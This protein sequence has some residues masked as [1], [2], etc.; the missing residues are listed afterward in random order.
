MTSYDIKAL[1]LVALTALTALTAAWILQRR[2]SRGA[3]LPLPPGPKGLPLL[4]NLL[5]MP[6]T[7]GWYKFHE[8]C[9]ELGTDIL[10]L[11][12][13]GTN[14]IVI[15]TA[16]VANDLLEKRSSIYS[17][18]P[19]MTMLNELSG[20][21]FNFGF[22]DYGSYWRT[23]RKLV[24][25]TFNQGVV[26]HFKPHVTRATRNMLNRFLDEPRK[27]EENLRNMAAE[28]IITVLYG[29]EVR[30]KDDFYMLTAARGVAPAIELLGAPGSRIVD[31]LPFLKHVPDWLPGVTFRH[32]AEEAKRAVRAM[33]EIPYKVSKDAYDK[34]SSRMVSFVDLSLGKMED[35]SRDNSYTEDDIKKVAGSLYT[36]GTETT[37]SAIVSCMLALVKNPDVLKRA[38]QELDSVIKDGEMPGLEDEPLL[39]FTTAVVNE[40]L[41]WREVVPQAIP[42]YLA[43]EDEYRGYRIPAKSIII[44]N[45]WAMLHNESIYPEPFKFYPER[46]LKDGKLDIQTQQDPAHACWGFGRRICPGRFLAYSAVWLGIASLMYVFDIEKAKDEDGNEIEP[47]EE[48]LSGLSLM[49][50]P[51]EYT[52]KP[53]SEERVALVRESLNSRPEGLYQ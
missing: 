29:I 1:G 2:V 6:D 44:P 8:L 48:F 15:D 22:Q 10:Y 25:L 50:K 47:R 21:D 46:F 41:R 40:A 51:F 11:N 27:M 31:A 14:I 20:W 5:D 3:R 33:L 39:P 13:A 12:V 19:R 42:H 9:K 36:A 4:G 24:H 45:A 43:T 52:I 37:A 23:H 16:E 53:R 38:Q 32:R 17:G 35:Q 28:T 30:Q 49:A 26:G 7:F 34:C 18:R